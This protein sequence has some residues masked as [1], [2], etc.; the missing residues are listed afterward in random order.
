VIQ[1]SD[2]WIAA[3]LGKVT[4]SRIS[5][6]VA[7]TK[8][9]GWSESRANYMAD[10]IT[11]R[12]TGK[13]AEHYISGPMQRGSETEAEGR[14][15]YQFERGVLVQTVSFFDHPTIAMSGASPDGFVGADGGIELKC[16]NTKTHLNYL[17]GQSI[18]GAYVGQMQWQMGTT[19]RQWV[20]WVSYD[21]RLP[22]SMQL[23]IRRVQRDDRH[24]AELEAQVREFI[25]ELDAKLAALTSRYGTPVREA[26]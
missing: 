20:D 8:S 18:P 11:E 14:A 7:K 23:H 2:E 19:G 24:I 4:A 16:P 1:G 5:D 10:L 9:G 12:L 6:V 17:L 3:R 26:A 25:S 15:A 22:E 13:Q 21:N